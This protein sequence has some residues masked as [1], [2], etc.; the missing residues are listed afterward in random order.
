MTK[1]LGGGDRI[2]RLLVGAGLIVAAF[3]LAPLATGWAHWVALA[4]GVVLI[5]TALVAVCPAY[6]PFGLRTCRR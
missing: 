4:V 3:I 5:L 2:I 6:L 1:N